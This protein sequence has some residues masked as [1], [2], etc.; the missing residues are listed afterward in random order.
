MFCRLIATLLIVSILGYGLALAA[1]VHGELSGESPAFHQ[2]DD[3]GQEAHDG[4]DCDHCSHGAVHLLGM[5]RRLVLDL[6]PAA[7]SHAGCYRDDSTSF[8]PAL[9]LRPPIAA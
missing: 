7:D 1:D 3:H 6:A 2:L 5:E 4:V 8:S 9:F